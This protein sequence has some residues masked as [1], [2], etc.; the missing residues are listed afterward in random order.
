MAFAL[1][2]PGVR[3]LTHPAL[4]EPLK[5]HSNN[6]FKMLKVASDFTGS[7]AR[8]HENHAEQLQ[9]LVHSY[10]MKGSADARQDRSNLGPIGLAWESLLQETEVDSTLHTEI[11]Q[12]LSR[13]VARPLL[14]NTFYRKLEARK[15]IAHRDSFDSI[16]AKAEE[17]LKKHKRDYVDAYRQHCAAPSPAS[18]GRHVDAHNAY[19][20]QLRATNGMLAEY[21]GNTLPALMQ[22]LDDVLADVGDVSSRCVSKTAEVYANKSGQQTKR[23]DALTRQCHALSGRADV[24]HLVKSLEV[25]NPPRPL[26]RF[27][28]PTLQYQPDQDP[29]LQEQPQ[30]TFG[31]HLVD[32]PNGRVRLAS[33]H[34]SLNR[35]AADLA[36][37][38]QAARESNET[39]VRSQQRS[40]ETGLYNR[41]NEQT[42]EI[43]LKRFDLRV[44]Q[45]HHGAVKAQKELFGAPSEDTPDARERKMSSSSSGSMKSKW[46]KAFK[47]LKTPPKE[48]DRRAGVGRPGEMPPP[49]LE[50]SHIFHEYTYKK[51]SACD[52]C[53]KVLIGHSRQG[54]KCKLCKTNVHPDCQP[55][56]PRCQP[57]SRLLRRQKSTSEIE[58]KHQEEPND[59]EGEAHIT[60]NSLIA[61]QP[62]RRLVEPPSPTGPL[63]TAGATRARRPASAMF[64]RS[65]SSGSGS[66]PPAYNDTNSMPRPRPPASSASNSLQRSRLASNSSLHSSS[67]SSPVPAEGRPPNRRNFSVPDRVYDRFSGIPPNGRRP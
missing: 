62:G 49:V 30:P 20:T 18:Q 6:T 7:L 14:Q 55:Q 12:T 45:L 21:H 42:E 33:R 60:V 16:I 41:V 51:V 3:Q 53:H 67:N 34:E 56:A 4:H 37:Q 36:R 46:M 2:E 64:Q 43:C 48:G 31:N 39:L 25:P 26:H 59:E 11:A 32:D 9:L 29:S 19:V 10:R 52:V 27:S 13:D 65:T 22:E 47:S 57:K 5:A 24:A 61:S 1:A 38:I 44:A 63:E 66:L 40:L 23:Y 17:Q 28:A 50:N 8:L 35:E 58:S 54:L 15:I